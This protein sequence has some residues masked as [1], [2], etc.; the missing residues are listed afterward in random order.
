M[1]I[2]DIVAQTEVF[3]A[4]IDAGCYALRQQVEF[5]GSADDVGVSLCVAAVVQ[6]PVR[7]YP[8][9]HSSGGVLIAVIVA[10]HGGLHPIG[11]GGGWGSGGVSAALRCAVLIGYGTRTKVCTTGDGINCRT[12][13]DFRTR[14]RNTA[15]GRHG[16]ADRL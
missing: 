6:C 2:G 13:Y 5:L 14:N 16:Y 8:K 12:L 1:A 9:A 15:V 11:T 10:R 4:V 7:N 3:A